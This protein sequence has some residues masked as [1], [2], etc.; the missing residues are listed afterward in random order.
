MQAA[1][2]SLCMIVKDEELVIENCLA[3]VENLVTEIIIVDTGSTDNTKEIARKY[4]AK[5]FDFPWEN[6][7]SKARNYSLKHSSCEWILLLDADEVLDQNDIPKF[8]S[9]MKDDHYDGYHFTILNYI[10]E[11]NTSDYATHYAFRFL[12]N[13]NTYQFVGNIHEQISRIDGELDSS[14]FCLTDIT[15]YHYGYTSSI[16]NSKQKKAR[17]MPLLKIALEEN[18]NNSFFLFNM[19]NEYMADNEYIRALHYYEQSYKNLTNNQSYTPH[20]FYRMILCYMELKNYNKALELS[21]QALFIYPE[22]TDIEYCKAIIYHK[23]YS[24]L[25]AIKSLLQCMEMGDPPMHLKFLND[26]ATIRSYSLLGE[27][28]NL[29]GD[30]DNALK[31]Y[32]LVYENT[33]ASDTLYKIAPL[34]NR[35]NTDKNEVANMMR[36]YLPSHNAQD[37]IFMIKL[38]LQEKLLSQARIYLMQLSVYKDFQIEY[39][40]LFTKLSFYDENYRESLK[41]MTSLLDNTLTSTALG[42]IQLDCFIMYYLSL[43][44]RNTS[45]EN[46]FPDMIKGFE[47]DSRYLT[48]KMLI[49]LYKDKDMIDLVWQN[50]QNKSNNTNSNYDNNCVNNNKLDEEVLMQFIEEIIITGKLNY[51]EEPIKLLPYLEYPYVYLRLAKLYMKYNYQDKALETILYSVKEYSLIDSECA[52]YLSRNLT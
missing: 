8:A 1:C 34:L 29:Q 37:L 19:G 46:T 44:Y 24:H 23:T 40:F 31:M 11:N 42:N 16:V 43:I 39:L 50:E 47:C 36:Q 18:P 20:L 45:I 35:I 38:L 30:Y 27:I 13:T 22:C 52:F 3:S 7:F 33:K 32:H 4:G 6:D 15:L 5:I 41:Q 12:R 9:L 17:N 14:K 48:F 26:C 25:L 2:I 28:Y 10:D 21:H 51:L 49:S